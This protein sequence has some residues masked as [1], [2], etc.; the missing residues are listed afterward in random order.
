MTYDA[1]MIEK[2]KW[3]EQNC[4]DSRYV[5]FVDKNHY[6]MQDNMYLNQQTMKDKNLN[7]DLFY[8]NRVE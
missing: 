7:I 4:L 2:I 6:L 3:D 5:R 1:A 8:K